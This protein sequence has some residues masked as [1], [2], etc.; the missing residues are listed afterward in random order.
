MLNRYSLP[1]YCKEV[2]NQAQVDAC[3]ILGAFVINVLL[4]GKKA[5]AYIDKRLSKITMPHERTRAAAE[6]FNR[7]I[8]ANISILELCVKI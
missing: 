5:F 1:G 6:C 3:I 7:V 4:K 2:F 8:K